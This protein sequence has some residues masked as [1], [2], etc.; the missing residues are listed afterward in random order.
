MKKIK[1]LKFALI[2]CILAFTQLY[3][4]GQTNLKE[5]QHDYGWYVLPDD[6][7]FTLTDFII[8]C[9]N[10][11]SLS[12]YDTFQ[13]DTVEIQNKQL[14]D[15]NIVIYKLKHFFNGTEVE[16]SQMIV[17]ERLGFIQFA[18]GEFLE[19]IIDFIQPNSTEIS[20]DI[21]R[22]AALAKIG[23]N[24][25]WQDVNLEK[26][27]TEL[28]EDST[29][30]FY[31]LVTTKKIRK[32]NDIPRLLHEWNITT[33]DTLQG[34]QTSLVY[35][36]AFNANVTD[37]VDQKKYLTDNCKNDGE[38]ITLYYG[39]RYDMKTKLVAPWTYRLKN[40]NKIHSVDKMLR[41]VGTNFVSSLTDSDNIWTS[42]EERPVTTAHWAACKIQDYFQ[43]TFGIRGLGDKQIQIEAGIDNNEA[44][45]SLVNYC[46][47]SSALGNFNLI[48]IGIDYPNSTRSLSTVDII[49]HEYAHGII[50]HSSKLSSYGE[51]GALNESFAD[52]FSNLAERSILGRNNWNIGEDLGYILRDLSNPE[53]DYYGGDNWVNPNNL[54]VD[55][56]GIHI[57]SGVQ[58]KWFQLIFDE[59]GLTKA[60]TL[61]FWTEKCLNPTSTYRDSKNISIFLSQ[62]FFGKCS[63]EHKAVI[64]AWY[65]V[66]VSQLNSNDYCREHYHIMPYLM[67]NQKIKVSENTSS[68]IYPNPSNNYININLQD[69]ASIEIINATGNIVKSLYLHFGLNHVNIEDLPSG[70]YSIYDQNNR[71]NIGKFIISK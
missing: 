7:K 42:S 54:T 38:V 66:G 10:S 8:T 9:R 58:S 24:F 32:I 47:S 29:A 56:G 71:R 61:V 6:S 44:S 18:Y 16:N 63:Q 4:N 28:T 13:I 37:V 70:I 64:D 41:I 2:L 15:S 36:D 12:N 17:F 21:S 45:Y 20:H 59:I 49:A 60:R 35:I 27:L 48:R 30:T 34:L 31:P 25:A 22:V 3:V 65:E 40:C 43:N 39:R 5:F 11:F 57:N 62:I 51:S 53:C 46:S 55:N 33:Y 19:R 23:S 52:I 26:Y 1:N 69:N 68:F 14:I 67:K 50:R